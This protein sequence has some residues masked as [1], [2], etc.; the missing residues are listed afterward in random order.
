MGV[1]V[2]LAL[3]II[4]GEVGITTNVKDQSIETIDGEAYDWFNKKFKSE[5]INIFSDVIENFYYTH[6]NITSF[7]KDMI[8]DHIGRNG[9]ESKIY[10][11]LEVDYDAYIKGSCIKFDSP[12]KGSIENA[13]LILKKI[14][15]IGD[16]AVLDINLI[17][18]CF[19]KAIKEYLTPYNDK[20]NQYIVS[21][22]IKTLSDLGMELAL[23]INHVQNYN[24]NIA[25]SYLNKTS[26]NE[27]E[28]EQYLNDANSLKKRD[29]SVPEYV[30]G[31]D[32][33]KIPSHNAWWIDT[34]GNAYGASGSTSLMLHIEMAEAISKRLYPDEIS[35]HNDY[36]LLDEKRYAKISDNWL[37]YD[38]QYITGLDEKSQPIYAFKEPLTDKQVDTILKIFA[39]AR[40]MDTFR[41]G[42]SQTPIS[43]SKFKQMEP[44]MR[45]QLFKL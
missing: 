3:K 38:A 11:S 23:A 39:Y 19:E 32:L 34:E 2:E 43:A 24:Y 28:I 26:L 40:G 10:V 22:S 25:K 36:S 1:P 6:Y 5:M 14:E 12:I 29:L 27:H 7:L 21:W 18:E 44:L 15:K 41:V 4:K 9:E 37:L 13:E 30:Y 42:Y 35:E 31:G 17:N 20:Y 16:L 45:N 8:D 33:S